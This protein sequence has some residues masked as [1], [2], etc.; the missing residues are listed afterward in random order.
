MLYDPKRDNAPPLGS[1]RWMWMIALGV[2]LFIISGFVF[3][4]YM[5]GASLPEWLV[6]TDFF[7]VYG[8]ITAVL[9][10]FYRW[11]GY[12]RKALVIEIIL[13]AVLAAVLFLTFSGI[14]HFPPMK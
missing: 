2:S 6:A 13:A 12:A 4:C 14:V 9:S 7:L 3:M 11:I 10:G 1:N 8:S 5:Y